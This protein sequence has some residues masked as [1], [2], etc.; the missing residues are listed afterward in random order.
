MPVVADP[1]EDIERLRKAVPA[2][3]RAAR[4]RQLKPRTRTVA[5]FL[6]GPIP[7]PWLMRAA[8]LPGQ[9]FKVGVAIWHLAGLKKKHTVALSLTS[10]YEE[11]AV[12]RDA[13]RRGLSALE[14]A[15]LV[16][17][18]RHAGRKPIVTILGADTGDSTASNDARAEK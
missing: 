10:L 13:A 5:G 11:L 12:H 9:A 2:P 3:I 14:A 16:S 1:F 7:W 6:K 17:V 15:G 18:Q 4:V 8:Q